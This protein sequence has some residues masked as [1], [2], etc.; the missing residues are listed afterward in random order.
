MD[1][2]LMS[3]ADPEWQ[4]QLLANYSSH[5]F[6]SKVT[7]GPDTSSADLMQTV[8]ESSLAILASRAEISDLKSHNAMLLQAIGYRQKWMRNERESLDCL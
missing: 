4:A 5:I 6:V 1:S 8:I 7:Q 2:Q 3:K